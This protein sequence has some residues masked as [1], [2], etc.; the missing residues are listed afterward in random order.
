MIGV[1]VRLLAVPLVAEV[2]P[3]IQ[4]IDVDQA[5]TALPDLGAVNFVL[6]PLAQPVVPVA[7]SSGP[8]EVVGLRIGRADESG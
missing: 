8:G 4:D 1:L 3:D 7:V 5:K 6:E 2:H